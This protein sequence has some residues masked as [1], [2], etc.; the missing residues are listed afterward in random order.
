MVRKSTPKIRA[1]MLVDHDW[2]VPGKRAWLAF[3]SGRVYNMTRTQADDM[4]G[5]F[6]EINGNR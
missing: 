6:E 5:L 4:A 1:L 3:K 2:P